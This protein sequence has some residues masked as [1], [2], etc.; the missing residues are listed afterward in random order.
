[1]HSGDGDQHR[2]LED[3]T[4]ASNQAGEDQSFTLE[5]FVAP[6]VPIVRDST[7]RLFSFHLN[8][9]D[10]GQAG[11]E[12]QPGPEATIFPVEAPPAPPLPEEYS[13]STA[14]ALRPLDVTPL[15]GRT[16]SSEEAFNEFVWLFEYGLEMDGALLNSAD[17]LNGLALLY[18]SALLKGYD[19]TFSALRAPGTAVGVAAI[20]TIVP[21]NKLGVEVWGVL[22]RIPRHLVEPPDSELAHLDRIH[23]ALAPHG[24]FER[25]SVTVY[26]AQREREI[27]CFTYIVSAAARN[28]LQ[29]SSH[30]RQAAAGAYG[31]RLL[32]VAKK[33][34]LPATYLQRLA[35]LTPSPPSLPLPA[36]VQAPVLPLAGEQDTEPLPALR[37][38]KSNMIPT[39]PPPALSTRG[40]LTFALY[41]GFSLLLAFTLAA[42]QALSKGGFLF[43]PDYSPLGVPWFVALY[44]YIGGCLSCSVRLG[45]QH[46]TYFPSYVVAIWFTRPFIGVILAVTGYLLVNS[47]LFALAGAA[48]QHNTLYALLAILAGSCEGWLFYGRG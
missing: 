46:R 7:P 36:P 25:I 18:G 39:T 43:A 9:S 4:D 10:S 38:P 34:K 5:G 33:Q 2:P 41:S 28:L 16:E 48:Q 27:A 45:R 37:A 35:A 17:R 40:M 19:I 32:E 3:R 42:L 20:A 8:D 21:S 30:D 29:I 12:P 15:P 11:A 13:A 26:E 47:G 24:L 1:M 23:D 31:R 6:G 14:E 22:Y 44:G